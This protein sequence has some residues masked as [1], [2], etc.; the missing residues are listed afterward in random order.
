MIGGEK[1]NEREGRGRRG[2]RNDKEKIEGEMLMED[3]K[4][5]SEE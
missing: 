4:I 5:W 3:D 1:E 2:K